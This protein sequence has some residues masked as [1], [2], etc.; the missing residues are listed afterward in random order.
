MNKGDIDIEY[1][2]NFERCTIVSRIRKPDY[3]FIAGLCI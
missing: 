2:E 1:V 3:K